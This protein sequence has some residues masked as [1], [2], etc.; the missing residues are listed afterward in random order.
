MKKWTKK[1]WWKRFRQL[2]EK[3]N[4]NIIS[5]D[6]QKKAAFCRNKGFSPDKAVWYIAANWIK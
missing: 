5:K 3:K 2:A 6:D 4:W 1:Q